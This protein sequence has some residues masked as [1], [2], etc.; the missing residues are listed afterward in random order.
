LALVFRTSDLLRLVKGVDL[1]YCAIQ[2][3]KITEYGT[4]FGTFNF[5]L[6][7]F[8]AA[9]EALSQANRA[10]I[11]MLQIITDSRFLVDSATQVSK[12]VIISPSGTDPGSGAFF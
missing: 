3:T 4:T 9:T 10:G 11:S 7:T 5:R 6:L 8:Q 1:L 12:P 2:N